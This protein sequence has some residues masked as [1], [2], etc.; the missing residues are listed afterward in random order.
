MPPMLQEWW[1]RPVSRAWRVGEQRAVVWKRLYFRPFAASF[2]A[3]GV[4]HGPPNALAEPNPA[5][6]SRMSRTLGAPLG[7][8]SCSIGGNFVSGSF[9]SK[10]IKPRRVV[11]GIGRWERCFRS[12]L[13]MVS[14]SLVLTL[15][16]ASWARSGHQANRRRKHYGQRAAFC[17]NV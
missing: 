7:G 5:S 1:L 16:R 2:S 15:T 12:S 8:R 10:V 9:A 11:F 13:F 17:A 3:F 14:E 4:W 6:S